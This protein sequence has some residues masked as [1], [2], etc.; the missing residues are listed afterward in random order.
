MLQLVVDV[1]MILSVLLRRRGGLLGLL[2]PS[3]A[4]PGMRLE[5]TPT[6]Q[7]DLKEDLN[8]FSAFAH[9]GADTLRTIT[10][11]TAAIIAWAGG[12][13]ASLTDSVSAL[14]VSLIIIAIGCHVAA[15]TWR[16]LRIELA[17]RRAGPNAKLPP[18]GN[19][20]I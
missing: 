12:L 8:L 20:A 17:L 15:E 7:T 14:V 3:P 1:C 18:L 16:Q 11:L 2:C 6:Q 9:V 13:N 19:G 5:D 4:S 10:V